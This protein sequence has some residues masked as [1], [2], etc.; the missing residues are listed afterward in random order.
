MNTLKSSSGKKVFN[1]NDYMPK[2]FGLNFSPP[3][4]SNYSLLIIYYFILVLEYLVQSTGKLYHHKIKI[5]KL[6]S[7]SNIQEIMKEVYEKNYLY[8]D[9]K[10]VNPEQILSIKITKFI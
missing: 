3:Q 7:E 2:R 8:L 4:I 9:S 10:K 1:N 5:H 6:S